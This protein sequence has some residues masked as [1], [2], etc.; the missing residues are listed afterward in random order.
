MLGVKF[1]SDKRDQYLQHGGWFVKIGVWVICNIVPFLL[2]AGFIN[3]YGMENFSMWPSCQRQ[4]ETEALKAIG[5]Q[6]PC[7]NPTSKSLMKEIMCHSLP[8]GIVNISKEVH[9][10]F[11]TLSDSSQYLQAGWPGLGR[12]YS[13]LSR[14]SCSWILSWLG[15]RRGLTRRTRGSLLALS[16]ST[17]RRY[18][19]AKR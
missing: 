10:S 16:F 4:P 3:S 1:K 11:L 7:Q 13:S 5:A 15:M 17:L 9:S 2:P 18:E 6:N 14:S 19:H 12:A 8:H